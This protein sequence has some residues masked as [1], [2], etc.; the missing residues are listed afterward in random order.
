MEIFPLQPIYS[1]GIAVIINIALVFRQLFLLLYF[2]RFLVCRLIDSNQPT[3]AEKKWNAQRKLGMKPDLKGHWQPH[4]ISFHGANFL[5]M[6][7]VRMIWAVSVPHQCRKCILIVVFWA[8]RFEDYTNDE[9]NHFHFFQRNHP[10][11]KMT[12]SRQM[13]PIWI[14]SFSVSWEMMMTNENETK[15]Q[16]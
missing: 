11:M 3:T 12:R 1:V 15:Q 5:C 9:D 7:N 2:V 10:L 8:Q 16:K 13:S 14:K 6:T 4:I